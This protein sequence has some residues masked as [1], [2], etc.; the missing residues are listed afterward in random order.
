[1]QEYYD[2]KIATY[3]D[4]NEKYDD[5]EVDVAFLGDSLTDGYDLEKYYPQYLVLN[6]GIGGET[7]F[8]L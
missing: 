6:R 8:G 5:Y 3:I 7:T 2:A 4:E 1:M